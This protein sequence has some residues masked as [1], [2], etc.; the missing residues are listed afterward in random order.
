MKEQILNIGI[1][2]GTFLLLFALAETL[3]HKASVKA[4]Y[5]R[6]LV[7]FGTGALTMLFPIYLTS[8]WQVLLMCSSFII[9]LAASKRFNFL[10]SINGVDRK[11]HGSIL[12]PVVV[13]S[14]FAMSQYMSNAMF[15]Y[16][17]IL[18]L[19][20]SD[21]I[22]ALIGKKFPVAKYTIAGHTKT[23]VGSMGFLV[24]S[25]LIAFF[26]LSYMLNVS[27]Q[28]GLLAVG[29]VALATCIAEAISKDGWDNFTIP[30]AATIVL[31]NLNFPVLC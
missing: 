25:A 17:P 22:A 20:I 2:S 12:F 7:H 14:C 23:L 11:T 6:K 21:P 27:S 13:Y 28:N 9:L 18:V 19:A 1:L 31:Y 8:H 4:E 16:L 29:S 5:T 26:C 10:P 15:F 24:S 30:F 3:F